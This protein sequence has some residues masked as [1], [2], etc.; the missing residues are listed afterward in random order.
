MLP[1]VIAQ[2]DEI[3]EGSKRN[4]VEQKAD[5]LVGML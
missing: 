1:D 3:N 2:T 5:L 4:L